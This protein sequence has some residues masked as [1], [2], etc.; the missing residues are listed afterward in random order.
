[1]VLKSLLFHP[2]KLRKSQSEEL[3]EDII[4]IIHSFSGR[5]YGL[6]HKINK[7]LEKAHDENG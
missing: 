3:A 2:K 7:E 4:A 6:R 5:L 1:M